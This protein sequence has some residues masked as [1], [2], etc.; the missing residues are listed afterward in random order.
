MFQIALTEAGVPFIECLFGGSR[1]MIDLHDF[2]SELL[3]SIERMHTCRRSVPKK[4][5]MITHHQFIRDAHQLAE[6]IWSRFVNRDEIAQ[7]LAHFPAAIQ[8]LEDREEKDDLLRQTFAFLKIA[9]DQNVEK[10]VRS[11][12]L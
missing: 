4:Q 1:R 12:E 8:T 3:F 2:E 5:L 9:P 11:S 10:L 7:A 6:H